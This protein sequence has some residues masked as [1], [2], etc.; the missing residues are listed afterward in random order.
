MAIVE[1]VPYVAQPSGVVGLPENSTNYFYCR[2]P[3]LSAV[4]KYV[5]WR[6]FYVRCPKLNLLCNSTSGAYCAAITVCNQQLWQ[7]DFGQD[8]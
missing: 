3:G 2:T 5:R 6:W 7:N 4:Y 8:Q 1:T